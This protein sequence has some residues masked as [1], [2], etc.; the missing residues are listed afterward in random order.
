MRMVTADYDVAI[1]G[2]GVV[3]AAIARELSRFDLRIAP[4]EAGPAVGTELRLEERVTALERRAGAWRVSTSRGTLTAAQVVNAAGLYSDEVHRLAGA[5]GFT[6]TPR[7]GELLV[8][9]KLS[10]PLVSHIILP[11]PTATTKGVLVAPTV[12]GNVM[13]GPTAVDVADKIDTATT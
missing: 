9:D 10:R 8:F 3:G 6:V 7:K 2:A 1:V 11:V 13:V 12:F 4:V 5:G